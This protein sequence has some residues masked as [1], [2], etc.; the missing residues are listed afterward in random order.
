MKYLL[1]TYLERRNA[2]RR[3]KSKE[4]RAKAAALRAAKREKK[5][6]KDEAVDRGKQR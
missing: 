1:E 6:K 5:V 4:L 2:E 3:T